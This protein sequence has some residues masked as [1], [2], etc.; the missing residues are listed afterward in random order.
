MGFQVTSDDVT[1]CCR[2]ASE[3]SKDS[4]LDDSDGDNQARKISKKSY[5]VM[6]NNWL[7]VCKLN[8]FLKEK[9]VELTKEREV[10]KRAVNNYEFLAIEKERKVKKNQG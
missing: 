8:K 4:E 1:T 7:K 9:I 2:S 6:Y 3:F 5:Q 10:M